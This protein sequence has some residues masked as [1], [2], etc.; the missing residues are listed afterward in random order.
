[1]NEALQNTTYKQNSS[2]RYGTT[3]ILRSLRLSEIL[4]DPEQPS[5]GS[6]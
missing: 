4:E 2:L 5:F 6:D 1:M 3:R